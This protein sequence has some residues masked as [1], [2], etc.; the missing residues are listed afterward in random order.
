MLAGLNK[1]EIF[2]FAQDDNGMILAEER[3]TRR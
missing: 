1:D 2:R 3:L